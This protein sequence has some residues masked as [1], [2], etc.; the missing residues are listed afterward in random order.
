MTSRKMGV[1]EEAATLAS[2]PG[3]TTRQLLGGVFVRRSVAYVPAPEVPRPGCL[4]V[5]YSLHSASALSAGRVGK[6]GRAIE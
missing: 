5:K 3:E 2:G 4:C 1:V 6:R